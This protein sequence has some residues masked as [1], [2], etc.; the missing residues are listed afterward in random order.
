MAI[1]GGP[2]FAFGYGGQAACAPRPL[3]NQ[4]VVSPQLDPDD[5]EALRTAMDQ[6][7]DLLRSIASKSL[8]DVEDT[9]VRDRLNALAWLAAAGFL[10]IRLAVRV[11]GDGAVARGIYHEKVGIFTDANGN[12]VA[13]TVRG[14]TLTAL[15]LASRVAAKNSLLVLI[16]TCPFV[17]L[18]KQWLREMLA[19]G[20]KQMQSAPGGA[21]SS[22]PQERAEHSSAN[23]PGS[24]MPADAG[25]THVR[26]DSQT[27]VRVG[28]WID[29]PNYGIGRVLAI[30]QLPDHRSNFRVW[31]AKN[32]SILGI[33]PMTGPVPDCSPRSKLPSRANRA[34]YGLF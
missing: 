23:P 26:L 15:V 19:F 5:A 4:W 22:E 32:G 34:G 24:P 9:L 1:R 29:D 21:S 20:L 33:G 27:T 13:F 14:K 2:A 18:C 6:P 10:Q 11:D 8:A 12:H 28:T 25:E 30:H 17:N 3:T 16:V 31:F 7:H